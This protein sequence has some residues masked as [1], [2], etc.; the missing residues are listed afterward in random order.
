MSFKFRAVLTAREAARVPAERR[1]IRDR[2]SELMNPARTRLLKQ[3]AG[4]FPQA[5][6]K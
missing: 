5:V 2:L 3:M 6:M 1:R 4:H